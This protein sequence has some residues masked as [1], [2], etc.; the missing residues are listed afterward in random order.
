MAHRRAYRP[1]GGLPFGTASYVVSD[2]LV[3]LVKTAAVIDPWGA[4]SP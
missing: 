1:V 2:S 4:A 3:T